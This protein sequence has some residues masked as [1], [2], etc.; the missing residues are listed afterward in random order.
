[1]AGNTEKRIT[2]KMVLDSTGYNNSIKGINSEMKNYQSQMKVA[3]EGIKQ[4]GKDTEKLKSVQESL[5]RQVE[6]HS[7]KIDVYKQAM[8]KTTSKMQENIKERDKFKNSLDAANRKYDEAVKLYGK[9]SE[10]AKKAKEEVEK[11]EKE[12][13]NKEKA[14][15]SNAKQVQNY[16]RNMNNANTTMIRAQGELKRISEEL[17]RSNNK[18]LNIS[19]SLEKG[20][21]KFKN[22]GS[23]VSGVGDK[24]LKLTAPI[25]AVGIAG[26]K[27]GTD[28]NEA[29]SKVATLIPGQQKRLQGLKSDVQNV[30]IVAGK[31]TDDIADGT[32]QVISAFGD[33]SDTMKKVEIDAKAATAGM[34]TTTDALNLSSA[35][36]KGY[37]DTTAE[38]NQK[39]MDMSFMTVKLGQTSFPELASSIGKVVPL[40]NELKVS[41]EELFAIYATGTG[42]TGGASEVS[43]QYR[44]ILQSLLAPTKS[45]TDL[46]TEMGYADGKAMLEK[47]GLIGAIETI[48]KKSKE[49]NT[50]LQKYIGSIE[51]QTLALA[52]AGEQ[53][54]VYKDKLEEMKNSSGALDEAFNEQTNG[55]NKTGFAF[56]Q[57][58]IKMQVAGQKLGDAMAPILE[59]GAELFTKLA[60][61]LG[62]L[63]KEQL[64]SYTKW[65]MMAI[66]SGGALKILGGGIST[67]GN[68]AGGLSKLTGILGA[69]KT[70]TAGVGTAASVAGGA[71]GIGALAT[72]LGG[73]VVAAA[74]FVAGAAAIGVAAYGIH[75]VMSKDA[76]PSVDLFE[77][78]VE[79]TTKTVT[80]SSGRLRQEAEKTTITISET[81]KKSVEAYLKLDEGA[82]KSLTNLYVNGTK[83]TEDN[84]NQL[85]NTYSEMSTQIKG[86]VDKHYNEEVENMKQFFSNSRNITSEE[87]QKILQGLQEHNNK[88]KQEIDGYEKRI[89]EIMDKA[90]KENRELK[91]E[92]QE[93]I[94][95][96]Q[97]KMKTN[98]V[99]SLS[100]SEVESKVILER[101]KGYSTRIT[102]EQASEVI[103]NA[104]KQRLE[105]VGNAEKQYDET[106]RNIVKLRDESKKITA[107]QANKMI[108]EAERQR[109]ETIKK[110]DEQKQGIVNKIKDQNEEVLK[111]IDEGDGEIMSKWDK[112]K[113]WFADNPITRFIKTI[114][115]GG[116][117][118]AGRNWTGTNYWKGGLT[119]LHDASGRNSNYELYDLPRGTRVFNHDASEDM[120]RQ[121]AEQVATKVAN[122]VLSSFN[123]T[124]GI[125]VTQNIYS[126]TPSPSEVS[127]QTKNSLRELALNF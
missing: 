16:E 43:T 40:S 95:K 15:E 98:A 72:G 127:R 2:A 48:V 76:V 19:E 71:G 122:S 103:K 96:I 44:G 61:K 38:A 112:L 12:Y 78:K 30:A 47:Q 63:S 9:E 75:K 113:N 14:V 60:D 101:L 17:D 117:E 57:A 86:G 84:K 11:L 23:A 34:A 82:T 118:E 125:N 31:S 62:S 41:Q 90:S 123:G 104:E 46:I 39:V 85:I 73:A 126:P 88:Q 8:E 87:Q 67:I 120:V 69:A 100:D 116:D 121:T 21:E 51:G 7:K 45:M 54:E 24:I 10:Q 91:K 105:S 1:M 92:E 22:M 33:A 102:T 64:E 89:K 80:D 42:V 59:K 50:P 6:L 29:M 55:I 3:S 56:K 77:K 108:K 52:L 99:K 35:V 74:P 13:K 124:G 49:I 58:T 83:I 4:F 79:Y 81:T 68:I 32:Y 110:A 70:A 5:T 94:N 111:N 114:T 106:L 18:W 65:G 66:A 119:Y 27:L 28:L 109:D 53:S 26:A 25:S 93:E 107:D 20:S 37:G 97:D 36:M 115:S